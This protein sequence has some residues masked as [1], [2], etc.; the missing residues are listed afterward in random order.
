MD[1]LYKGYKGLSRREF[2]ERS[3]LAGTALYMGMGGDAFAAEPP[4]ETTTLRL[5]VWRPAC[6]APIHVAEPLLREEGFT[7]ISTLMRDFPDW[8]FKPEVAE[9]ITAHYES[10]QANP[11]LKSGATIVRPLPR[12]EIGKASI[13]SS[14]RSFPFEAYP[15]K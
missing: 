3:A 10:L 9:L 7:N 14:R 11:G 1:M 12:S 5:R 4:P 6:W 2:L 13:P 8:M 15:S